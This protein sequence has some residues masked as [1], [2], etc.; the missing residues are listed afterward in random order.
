M[1]SESRWIL[2]VSAADRPGLVAA[3]SG[4]L[5]ERRFNIR[6]A[7][8]HTDP[9][10]G[11]F[12]QRLDVEAADTDGVIR[13]RSDLE[14]LASKLGL[15]WELHDVAVRPRIAV[16]ASTEAHC[17][18][19]L[20]ARQAAGEFAGDIVAVISNHS[21]HERLCEHFDVGHHYLPI[22]SAGK[23]AQEAQIAAVLTEQEI[24]LVVLARYMQI[25]SPDLVSEYPDRIINIHHS[26]L[27][28][29]AGARPYHHAHA[30][31]VKLIGATA[32]YV[33]DDLD[34][35]PIIAQDTIRV[36][37]RDDVRALVQRGRDIEKIVLARAVRL[38]LERR[39]MV[40]GNRTVVFG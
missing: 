13:L 15:R 30:R 3:V 36:S 23:L 38:H 25:L 22:G 35:G 14:A 9:D 19:D 27:P 20:L 17:L 21:D 34:E 10:T 33:T 12:L 40:S 37:H 1:S 6:S 39:V 29:F 2:S 8:Q 32:H 24:D 31:G 18:V 16:L 26:F 7:D 5:F 11:I 28:A 4:A